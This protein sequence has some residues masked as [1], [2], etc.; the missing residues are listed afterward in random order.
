M[1]DNKIPKARLLTMREVLGIDSPEELLLGPVT[2]PDELKY[3]ENTSD[4][5]SCKLS[6]FKKR[7]I[8]CESALAPSY[9]T[10]YFMVTKNHNII[11]YPAGYRMENDYQ[12]LDEIKHLYLDTK[13]NLTFDIGVHTSNLRVAFRWS[14]IEKYCSNYHLAEDGVLEAEY[15]LWPQVNEYPWLTAPI[16]ERIYEYQRQLA[17]FDVIEKESIEERLKLLNPT[18]LQYTTEHK[19][20]EEGAECTINPVYEFNGMYFARIDDNINGIGGSYKWTPLQ[21][22]K[23]W[24][25]EEQ[26]V[27]V[28]ECAIC[29][30]PNYEDTEAYLEN[31]F[32]QEVF[33]G[34][35]LFKQKENS[36]QVLQE[37]ERIIY[38]GLKEYDPVEEEKP[39]FPGIEITAPPRVKDE[40][41]Y[42]NSSASQEEK[43]MYPGLKD[44]ATGVKEKP[45]FPGISIKETDKTSVEEILQMGLAKDDEKRRVKAESYKQPRV[46][47]VKVKTKEES[48]QYKT[49]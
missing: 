2:T 35:M 38:P 23:L 14:E 36:K 8:L 5:M 41:T 46:V 29:R 4:K 19:S 42:L 10:Q 7:G 17:H 47:K 40:R 45:M 11:K 44:V 43:I 33:S 49:N 3:L 25:D 39:M 37:E 26:D 9:R 24:I 27:A 20:Y 22:L 13:G 34:F 12:D 31:F 18:S 28:T 30:V 1:I 21:P 6:I 48:K 16:L 32:S 15:G